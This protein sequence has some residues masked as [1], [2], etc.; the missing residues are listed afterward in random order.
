MSIGTRLS[1]LAV[2]SAFA[3][4]GAALQAG[5]GTGTGTGGGDGGGDGGIDPHTTPP[6]VYPG[7]GDTVPPDWRPKP[8]PPAAAPITRGPGEPR[9]RPLPGTTTADGGPAVPPSIADTFGAD[10][11]DWSIWWGFN[12][13]PYLLLSRGGYRNL[14][15]THDGSVR[16]A[17]GR[18]GPRAPAEL[19]PSPET[20]RGAIVPALL[21]ALAA[22][23]SN[24]EVDAI[25][26]ALGRIGEE[27]ADRL[28]SGELTRTIAGFLAHPSAGIAENACVALGILGQP[29]AVRTLAAVAGNTEAGRTACG[30]SEVPDRMRAFAAYGLGLTAQRSRNVDVRRYAINELWSV[31]GRR[32]KVQDIQ[33]ACVLAIGLAASAGDPAALDDSLPFQGSAPVLVDSLLAFLEED[34]NDFLVRAHV[35][36]TLARLA[37]QVSEEAQ[38]RI[39]DALLARLARRTRDRNEIRQSCLLALGLVADADEDPR[40]VRVR[41]ALMA[42]AEEGD[43]LARAYALIGLAQIAG[44]RGTGFGDREAG[45]AEIRRFFFT[46]LPQANVHT[47]AWLA[48]ALGVMGNA[49][50][51]E[52]RPL[53]PAD[54]SAL[55]LHLGA[56]TSPDVVSSLFLAAGLVRDAEAV[57]VILDRIADFQDD[58]VRARGALA[59]GLTGSRDG[60]EPVRS[61]LL[62]ARYRP[63]L[64]VETSLALGLMGDLQ[65]VPTLL[66]ML[67]KADSLSTRIAVM[68][69]L[70]NAG[71]TRAVEP[72]LALLEEGSATATQRAWAAYSLGR[73]AD[74]EEMPWTAKISTDINYSANPPSLTNPDGAGIID[75]R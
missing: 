4:P 24:F 62:E 46:S 19:R 42:A 51:A 39:V 56:S 35:P 6:P 13:E 67:A 28:A 3:L 53:T 14:P 58:V 48:M 10:F 60:I 34:D 25:L 50:A 55:R 36:T 33:V 40:D 41:K 43:Q 12:R 27:P 69:A 23:P 63:L 30:R 52:N 75:F 15:L 21:A 16:R 2:A 17:G 64:L 73:L 66:G 11:T 7:P 44:R 31:L 22:N 18:T 45:T 49:L 38:A 47:K 37:N 70:G 32:Q 72:L 29:G 20:I 68:V 71:D 74:K 54:R 9:V 57:P 59:L 65:L 26:Q 5:G 61:L 8:G 1:A